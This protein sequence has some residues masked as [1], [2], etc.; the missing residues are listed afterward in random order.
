M[1]NEKQDP[2]FTP[3]VLELY[4]QVQPA[5]FSGQ[6]DRALSAVE[7]AIELQTAA[8]SAPDRGVARLLLLKSGVVQARGGDPR[9]ALEESV[10]LFKAANPDQRPDAQQAN[11]MDV[12]GGALMRAARLRDDRQE[13]VARALEL[14]RASVEMERAAHG[15]YHF[16]VAV[17]L[18]HLA[19]AQGRAG[20][21]DEGLA[22]LAEVDAIH[23][24]HLD[25]PGKATSRGVV[26]LKSAE[27]KC[28][29]G[30][31]HQIAGREAEAAAA[32]RE[33]LA[34]LADVPEQMAKS[35]YMTESKVTTNLGI[36]AV[37]A[38][39][40][41]E[42]A[43]L[44]G[45][46]PGLQLRA[47]MPR[48]H[49][50]HAT[51]LKLSGQVLYNAERFADA[52]PPLREALEIMHGLG[53]GG[54]PREEADEALD[55][56]VVSLVC[57]FEVADAQEAARRHAAALRRAFPGED[58][59]TWSESARRACRAAEGTP[60]ELCAAYD[61]PG[62]QALGMLLR[63]EQ[64]FMAGRFDEALAASTEVLADGPHAAHLP[65]KLRATAHF[66]RS[67]ALLCLDRAEEALA[68]ADAC[69][70]ADASYLRGQF[71]RA[72]VL[73]ALGR[74][75]EAAEA[76][77]LHG[78][79][80]LR[81]GAGAAKALEAY[82]RACEQDPE[83]AAAWSN[84]GLML[85]ALK[86]RDE[87]RTAYERALELAEQQGNEALATKVRKRLGLKQ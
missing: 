9:P 39:D 38:G 54:L 29:A 72:S 10:R 67:A 76:H 60:E 28:N 81:Q 82:E 63:G 20:S 5:L 64:A 51:A 14:M 57:T 30:A 12:L 80:L 77:K 4:K 17:R 43:R 16:N 13:D 59:S 42:A 26:R 71:Q 18:S 34:A 69:V 83:L 66:G 36:L 78:T 27:S 85:G 52:V 3:A 49:P 48:E 21:P 87:A 24:W 75:G 73:E 15:P 50:D 65:D 23:R 33:A 2:D 19:M 11:A 68:D 70:R 58:E 35:R 56:L 61:Q 46:V 55:M 47:G 84:R 7:R 8:A 86:R 41:A 31:L 45:A 6:A 62:L 25:N 53:L 22:L 32:F 40:D 1:A 37:N 74:R 79:V 44:L